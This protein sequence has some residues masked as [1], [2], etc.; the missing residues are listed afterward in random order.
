MVEIEGI[1]ENPHAREE[2]FEECERSAS[3][4]GDRKKEEGL[5]EERG[6]PTPSPQT[7]Q[8]DE[9]IG[10]EEMLPEKR[11]PFAHRVEEVAE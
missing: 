3:F 9:A 7:G 11:S 8:G 5:S 6:F 4:H 2:A 1:G 10:L